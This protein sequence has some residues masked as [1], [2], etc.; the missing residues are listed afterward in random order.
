METKSLKIE[1]YG[2]PEAV[3]RCAGCMQATKILKDLNLPY[4][5]YDV[6]YIDPVTKQIAYNRDLIVAL[7][8]RAGFPTLNIRYPVIFVDNVLQHNLRFFKQFL[9][10]QGFDPDLIEE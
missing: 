10:D 6:I 7:A 9:L 3:S 1:I 4:Q 8:K 2:I 5:F